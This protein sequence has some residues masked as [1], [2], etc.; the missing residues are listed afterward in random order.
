MGF[1]YRLRNLRP[2]S[3][4]EWQRE[5]S[6]LNNALRRP[7]ELQQL[8]PAGVGDVAFPTDAYFFVRSG[9]PA[10]TAFFLEIPAEPSASEIWGLSGA[11]T[12]KGTSAA[13]A[14]CVN[15]IAMTST[16]DETVITS[17]AECYGEVHNALQYV[18]L[19][20]PETWFTI[21]AGEVRRFHIQAQK[22]NSVG[23]GASY[24]NNGDIAGPRIIAR[25]IS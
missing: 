15:R 1:V 18:T 7:N 20:T 22:Y 21:P 8:C 25:R 6:E 3:W 10:T 11:L 4:Q 13:W 23:V 19:Q 24:F 17:G 2:S 5:L 12:I 9:N 16:A 14:H